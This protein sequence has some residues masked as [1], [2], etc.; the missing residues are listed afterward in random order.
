MIKDLKNLVDE[1]NYITEQIK[2]YDLETSVI[3]VE[4]KV[5]LL[6]IVYKNKDDLFWL[7][8]SIKYDERKT[9]YFAIEVF[10]NNVDS[11]WAKKVSSAADALPVLTEELKFASR[12]S[13]EEYFNFQ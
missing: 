1:F 9:P 5:D 4:N 8:L 13:F 7:T 6:N 10:N 3:Q 2:V 11:Q 12:C